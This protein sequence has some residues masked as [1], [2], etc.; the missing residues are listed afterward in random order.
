MENLKCEIISVGSE[1]LFGDIVD[2]N[3]QF[4]TQAL[5]E[6]GI[7]VFRHTSVRDSF[8]EILESVDNAFNRGIN[9]IITSGG[10]GPTDDD[11]TKEACAKYFGKKLIL[12]SDWV[13]CLE[14][15]L[16]IKK[17]N[18]TEANLKQAY[19]PEDSEFI[20]NDFGTAP[21]IILNLNGKIVIN[22][23][24][25]P[26]ELY[27]MFNNYVKNYLEKLTNTKYYSEFLRVYGI[28]EGN[29]NHHL[30]DLFSSENPTFAPYIKDDDLVLRITAKCESEN[31]GREIVK[32]FKGKVYERVGNFIYA[33]G[34]MEIEELLFYELKNHNFKI[35]FAESCTSGMVASRF[36]N[37]AG[38]SS[39]FNESFVTYS[40]ESKVKNL[41]VK[42][43]TL[44]NFGAVSEETAV[45][46]ANGLFEKTNSQVCISVTG[47]A[48]PG[49]SENKPAGL[50]YICVKVLDKIYVEKCNFNG[51]RKKVRE[52][53]TF[54]A[55]MNAY[56]ILKKL[57]VV[58]KYSIHQIG[59]LE[60]R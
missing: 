24:G 57:E 9:L 56:N 54:R 22:L 37:F 20:Q 10:L 21:G 49:Q 17:E 44:E 11:I 12:N 5:S 6:I 36:V 8:D 25:P 15:I 30:T 41:G 3:S 27:P 53:S 40:N 45:E 1:I 28:S 19:V 39:C 32:N 14:K 23:P 35:S 4:I 51:D 29:I 48:G 60:K 34:E 42:P 55:L 2:T 52:K 47:V 31:E 13:S 18:M 26:K 7:E 43:Q 50:V 46:M 59:T 58:W 38:A 16:K 33:E